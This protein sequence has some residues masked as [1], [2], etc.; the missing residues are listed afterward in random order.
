MSQ[1]RTL[2]P[3]PHQL[4]MNTGGIKDSPFF[5]LFELETRLSQHFSD[6]GVSPDIEVT[7]S[8]SVIA[9]RFTVITRVRLCQITR[10]FGHGYSCSLSEEGV[11]IVLRIWKPVTV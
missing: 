2:H 9:Y 10:N 11:R 4:K 3:N 6:S 1:N 5:P 8:F 7:E